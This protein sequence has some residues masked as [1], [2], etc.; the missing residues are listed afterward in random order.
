MKKHNKLHGNLGYLNNIPK[1]IKWKVIFPEGAELS[2]LQDHDL[3]FDDY[4]SKIRQLS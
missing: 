3:I 4:D 1:T 2:S